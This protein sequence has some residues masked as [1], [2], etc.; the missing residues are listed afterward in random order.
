[1]K[2][3]VLAG[4]ICTALFAGC[5]AILYFTKDSKKE[6]SVTEEV[7]PK[8]NQSV[9]ATNIAPKKVVKKVDVI[10]KAD[11]YASV[12]GL[13]L[14]MI[15]DLNNLPHNIKREA[16]KIIN[17]DTL[18]VLAMKNLHDKVLLIVE[19]S[20]DNRHGIEFIE[21]SKKDASQK[22]ILLSN[23]PSGTEQD[24]WRYDENSQLPIE[25]TKFDSEN[26]PEY[27]EIWNYLTEEPIKYE[28]KDGQG[29]VLS[30]KKET[31]DDSNNMR[32]E[33][34]TYDKHG[35][36]KICISTNYE[37]PNLTRFTYYNADKPDEGITIFSEY[38][39]GVKVK[40]NVYTSD[41]KLKNTY[42][43]VYKDGQR[44]SV[45]VYDKDNNEVENIQI[46]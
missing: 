46:K 10:K 24:V 5:C 1:M 19:N 7:K 2:K 38:S 3:Q 28:L 20:E 27:T 29:K 31:L 35:N 22:I 42:E 40:E 11:L 26:Q 44:E 17:D 6:S 4:I 16:D 25:H 15:T 36:T 12:V 32:Q 8:E 45:K 41:F 9:N 30:I 23:K 21:I 43:A 34:I 13:P 18:N 14:S 39:D 37:G 33:H